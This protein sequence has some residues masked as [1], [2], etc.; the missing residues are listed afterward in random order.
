MTSLAA[1][2]EWYVGVSRSLRRLDRLATHFWADLR[3][4]GRIGRD[5]LLREVSEDQLVAEVSADLDPLSDIGVFMLFAAFEAEVRAKVMEQTADERAQIAH[6]A[7]TY[8]MRQAVLSIEEGSFF[9]ILDGFKSPPLHDLIEQV[10]QVRRYR[11]WVAHGRRG[12]RPHYVS[13]YD[14]HARLRA[15]L[16]ALNQPP[17]A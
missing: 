5:H 14:A 4:G 8:W 16:D 11:N 17:P 1:A 7:L 15:F 9:R 13:P 6:P 10:N 2:W 3:E 12:T